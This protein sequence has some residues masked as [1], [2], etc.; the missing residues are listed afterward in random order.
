MSHI[1]NINEQDY[2]F[3]GQE[4]VITGSLNFYGDTRVAGSIIGD[5]K[6]SS[7]SPLTIEPHG[8]IEGNIICHDITVFGEVKGSIKAS[9]VLTVHPYGKV[10]GEVSAQSFAFKPGSIM[11]IDGQVTRHP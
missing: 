8:K 10:T 9:G 5:V 4:S 7:S 11:N 3:I 2:V 6:T 1:L